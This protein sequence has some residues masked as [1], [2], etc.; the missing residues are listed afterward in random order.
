MK[1]SIQV[2]LKLSGLHRD[3]LRLIRCCLADPLNEI[4]VL[5][6]YQYFCQERLSSYSTTLSEDLRLLE[7]I[8]FNQEYHWMYQ[9]VLL[10]RIG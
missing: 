7:E 10:Y 1:E 6:I 8:K 3:L 4:N 2:D 5:K 9:Y